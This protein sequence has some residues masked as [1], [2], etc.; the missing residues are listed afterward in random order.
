MASTSYK[1]ITKTISTLATIERE[2]RV[3][4]KGQWGRLYIIEDG[5]WNNVVLRLSGSINMVVEA[6]DWLEEKIKSYYENANQFDFL[7]AAHSYEEPKKFMLLFAPEND[8]SIIRLASRGIPLE[9]AQKLFDHIDHH[10]RMPIKKA[11]DGLD[12]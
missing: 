8:E 5:L 10:G 12:I 2:D 9:M 6:T 3:E 7:N 11:S 1:I 4:Y